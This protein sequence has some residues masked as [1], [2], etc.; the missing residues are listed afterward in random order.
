MWKMQLP[1]H[2]DRNPDHDAIPSSL[3]QGLTACRVACSVLARLQTRRAGQ[4]AA[5][6][7]EEESFVQAVED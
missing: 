7:G 5:M 4:A 1:S 2:R 3:E 6:L